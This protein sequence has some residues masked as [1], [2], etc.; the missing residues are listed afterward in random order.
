MG[1]TKKVVSGFSWEAILRLSTYALTI[2]KIY[3]LARILNPSDFGLFSLTAGA[4]GISEAI[5]Q[6]GINLTIIQSKHSVKYFIDTAWV[7]AIA[8]GF[9]IG[10]V[11]IGLG[12][13][14]SEYF[15]D[16]QLLTLTSVA[17][18]IPVIKGFINPYIVILHKKLLYFQDV[19]FRFGIMAVEIIAAILLGIWLKSAFALALAMLV[20]GIIEVLASFLLFKQKPKF[21]YRAS[22]AKIIFD[23]ARWLSIGS[24]LNYLVENVDDLLVG[25]LTST[26]ALGIYHNSYSLSHKANYQLSKAVHYGTIPVYTK[27]NHQLPRLKK[28]FFK[29]LAVTGLIVLFTSLPFLLFPEPIINLFLGEKWLEA[30]P[31][32][33]TL[34]WAGIIQ[35]FSMVSYTL[36][37]AVKKYFYMNLHLLFSLAAMIFFML[38]LGQQQGLSGAIQ[39]L[40]LSRIVV[41]PVLILGVYR[42]INQLGSD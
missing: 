41:I 39:G 14:M 6:T 24:L 31:L 34:I 35:S 15:N 42:T 23:N 21:L 12:Y 13:G 33:P 2:V 9:L 32:L 1:Y 19:L 3:F 22:R 16:P 4:L 36:L 29:S 27:I 17:A 38:Y 30:I 20:S 37:L 10:I 11:M 5:T 25:G 28:A 7:I 18:L 26:H 40:L 8:R